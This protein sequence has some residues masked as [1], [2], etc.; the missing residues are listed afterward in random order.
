MSSGCRFFVVERGRSV[1]V[2]VGGVFQSKLTAGSVVG[3]VSSN[4]AEAASPASA[5]GRRTFSELA[6][7][8]RSGLDT[9][10]VDADCE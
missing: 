1:P 8:L 2:H 4:F 5:A 6:S 7:S 3:S 10:P 9:A